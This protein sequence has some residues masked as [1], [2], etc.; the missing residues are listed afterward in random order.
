MAPK[1]EV[2]R[3]YVKSTIA[4][5][6]GSQLKRVSNKLEKIERKSDAAEMQ[7]KEVES[8]LELMSGQIESL[9]KHVEVE[10]NVHR[11]NVI[12]FV[13]FLL[14]ILVVALF[15]MILAFPSLQVLLLLVSGFCLGFITGNVLTE[16]VM[17]P[18]WPHR[19]VG[20]GNSEGRFRVFRNKEG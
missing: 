3:S 9:N 12:G 7:E 20:S 10:E 18:I 19:S 1:K 14:T 2:T 17:L 13:V 11:P 15:Y 6:A 5:S 16:K 4:K 8:K